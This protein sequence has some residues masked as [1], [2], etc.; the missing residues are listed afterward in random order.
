M[1]DEMSDEKLARYWDKHVDQLLPVIER[2]ELAG[3]EDAVALAMAEEQEEEG[4]VEEEVE[5]AR[6]NLRAASAAMRRLQTGW[7]TYREMFEA[8]LSELEGDG[9][10]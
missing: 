3:V 7:R 5:L 4:D 2:P 8:E 6:R 9:W 1:S 10:D